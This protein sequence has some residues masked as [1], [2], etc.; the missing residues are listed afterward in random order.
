MTATPESAVDSRPRTVLP[1]PFGEVVE[2]FDTRTGAASRN[3]GS[4][5]LLTGVTLTSK[6]VRPGDLYAAVAGAN[7]HGARFA[8]AA[9][10]AGAVAVL[11]DVTGAEEVA[12]TAATVPVVV[13]DDPRRELGDVAALVY[14][15][16]AER[17]RTIGVTG[18][19]GKTTVTYLAESG[20]AGAGDRAGVVGTIGTRIAGRPVSSALTTPEAPQLHGLFAAMLEQ[21]VAACVMEVSSH[22]LVLGRVGG[23]VFDVAVFLNLGH[24]HLDFHA[25][26]QEYFEAKAML[27]TAEH[28]RCAVINVDDD[29]GRQLL[30]RTELPVTTISA[31][32]GAG[33]AADWTATRHRPDAGGTTFD[34]I[35]PGGVTEVRVPLPGAF[36]VTNALAV[37]AALVAAGYRADEVAAGIA[38]CPGVPGRMEQ[39][40]AGQDFTALVD[41]AHKP[42]ALQ[43]VLEALGPVTDGR[44][45]VVVGA[46]G[47]RDT[48]KRPLMGRIAATACDLLIVTDDN[49]RTEDPAGIRRQ[50]I[51]GTQQAEPRRAEVVQIA[52]RRD[53][54]A[55]AVSLARTGDCLLVAGK[56]HERGQEINGTVHPFDDREVLRALLTAE[57]P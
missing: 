46:G 52:G 43:A 30:A 55:Y 16:P 10:A 33:R 56:G 45:I 20:V 34:A 53:A 15:H 17:L 24:D 5:V 28:A 36:N 12:R 13:V 32:A 22:A 26:L 18:T 54:I 44:L 7:T 14:G 42:E 35:G 6:D 21:Q 2:L 40:V 50:I 4:D 37:V 3:S 51:D 38:T 23:V 25:T 9:V 39:V 31:D 47:D 11:T 27:F 8:G 49:P 29:H 19:Q 41:Y 1:V 57:A 48:G